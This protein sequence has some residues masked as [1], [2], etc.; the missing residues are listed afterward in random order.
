MRK[1][2]DVSPSF[3][4]IE[5]MMYNAGWANLKPQKLKYT[6]KLGNKAAQLLESGE[7]LSAVARK[8]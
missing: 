2:E 5:L 8:S 6:A 4:Y 3:C 7:S 1:N